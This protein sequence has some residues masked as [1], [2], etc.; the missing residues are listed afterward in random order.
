MNLS[1]TPHKKVKYGRETYYI[2]RYPEGDA[3]IH[4][5]KPYDR[6]GYGGRT[7]KFLLDDGTI[8][9]VKGP[10]CCDGHFDFGIAEKLAKHLNDPSLNNM[11][12][13][14]TVGKDLFLGKWGGKKREVIFEEANFI[15]GDYRKRINPEW[16][17]FEIEVCIRGG[18]F[19]I[20]PNDMEKR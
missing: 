5:V 8:E 19:Y 10:Y 6:N 17:D 12:T 11:V 2:A 20:R 7:I 13:K 4:Q 9:E 3:H 15:M 16:I 14:L 1:K 18:S